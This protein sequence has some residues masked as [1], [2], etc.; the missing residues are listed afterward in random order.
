MMKMWLLKF[1]FRN[2]STSG[3]LPATMGEFEEILLHLSKDA[4]RSTLL[5]EGLNNVLEEWSTIAPDEA[6]Q[7]RG[8]FLVA[9]NAFD[10]SVPHWFTVTSVKHRGATYKAAQQPIMTRVTRNKNSFVLCRVGGIF[11]PAVIRCIAADYPLEAISSGASHAW[12][13][14]QTFR[15][16]EEYQATDDPFS[17]VASLFPCG[18]ARDIPRFFVVDSSLHETL[19]VIKSSDLR[20]HIS[21][22]TAR[23]FIPTH[24][25]ALVCGVLDRV[26]CSI[27]IVIIQLTLDYRVSRR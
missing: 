10:S 11:R 17:I 2:L 26:K 5:S 1:A 22:T 15:H 21:I 20:C 23:L 27:L 9:L 4:S 18:E 8:G 6:T 25:S 14:V 3:R 16:L 19:H 12:F 24:P 13:I 7:I